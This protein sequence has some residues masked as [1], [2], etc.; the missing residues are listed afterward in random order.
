MIAGAWYRSVSVTLSAKIAHQDEEPRLALKRREQRIALEERTA[1][2]AV[3]RGI[4]QPRKGFAGLMNLPSRSA[5]SSSE[6]L[7][8]SWEMSSGTHFGNATS[9]VTWRPEAV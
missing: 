1:P 3:E 6:S 9:L 7:A 8:A 2:I 4:G 5:A